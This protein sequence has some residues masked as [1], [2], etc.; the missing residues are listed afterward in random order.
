VKC[1]ATSRLMKV[2]GWTWSAGDGDDDDNKYLHR[3][4]KLADSDC[5]VV[6]SRH[7]HPAMRA[8]GSLRYPPRAR[9]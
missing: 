7:L 3:E 1:P 6:S 8:D 5:G 9:R 2:N 4:E